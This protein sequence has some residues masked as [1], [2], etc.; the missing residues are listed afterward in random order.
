M[1][2]YSKRRLKN[3]SDRIIKKSD[4]SIVDIKG[5]NAAYAPVIEIAEMIIT[6]SAMSISA[7]G[8]KTGFVVPY[9][10]RMETVF[11][12]Y[13]RSIIKK[14]FQKDGNEAWRI[15]EYRD[16]TDKNSL[17]R[18]TL[19]ENNYLMNTYIPDIAVQ[20]YNDEKMQWEYVGVFDVKYQKSKNSNSEAV[21]HNSHQLLFYALLLNVSKCGFIFPQEEGQHYEK[22]EDYLVIQE[23]NLEKS[24]RVYTEF[25]FGY[26]RRNTHNEMNRMIEYVKRMY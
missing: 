24:N 17:L 25:H 13:M 8:E 20:F 10:I 1:L 3:V 11:E 9:A 26:E 19:N 23:G 6:H 16:V 14:E 22:T 2:V 4:F 21:R 7:K 5:F 15:D 18:T 12:Y